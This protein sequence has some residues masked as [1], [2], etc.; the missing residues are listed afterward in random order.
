MGRKLGRNPRVQDVM[1]LVKRN[2]RQGLMPP[3][4]YLG[5]SGNAL[6]SGVG[7]LH[8]DYE[9]LIESRIEGSQQL[10]VLEMSEIVDRTS[11]LMKWLLGILA[12]ERD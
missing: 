3:A 4:K 9:K 10:S 11:T 1:K 12:E 5:V 8:E 6:A 2:L 7:Q